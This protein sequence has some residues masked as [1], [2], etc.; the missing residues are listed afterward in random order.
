MVKIK[1]LSLNG[2]QLKLLGWAFTLCGAV[3][4]TFF[5]D[6]VLGAVLNLVSYVAMP[7]FAFLLVEGFRWSKSLEK[8]ML[9][10]AVAAVVTEPFYD[11]AC[12]GSWINFDAWNGQ[13]FL[14]SLFL[15]QLELF[16][17]N[18]LGGTKRGKTF[19]SWALILGVVLWAFFLNI[20]G[21]VFMALAVG[22]MYLFRDQP[23]IWN[24]LTAVA[25]MSFYV[26]PAL[27]LLPVS[28]YNEER[29]EYNKYIFYAAFPVMWAI[30]AMVKLLM[31]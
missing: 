7:I 24:I 23:R 25:S 10:M 12:T 5:P 18:Y 19:Q 11:Y 3:G 16:F 28:R 2:L 4:L 15:C 8:F 30:L 20:R 21:G 14:A 27:G 17:L 29:G 13:N 31:K 6:S 22:V 26:T 1:E 9:C